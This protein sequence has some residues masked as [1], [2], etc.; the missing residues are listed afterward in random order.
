[1]LRLF[2]RRFWPPPANFTSKSLQVCL[3]EGKNQTPSVLEEQRCLAPLLGS[4]RAWIL[5]RAR[6]YS[7]SNGSPGFPLSLDWHHLKSWVLD[8]GPP[9]ISS[10]TGK[11]SLD[12]FLQQVT[13]VQKSGLQEMTPWEAEGHRDSARHQLTMPL[14]EPL[15]CFGSWFP[16]KKCLLN[17]VSSATKLYYLRLNYSVNTHYGN[18]KHELPFYMPAKKRLVLQQL[19]TKA[20]WSYQLITWEKSKSPNDFCITRDK[21]T[22]SCN[23]TTYMHLKTL[24]GQ[25]IFPFR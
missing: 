21:M 23:L 4:T 12:I 16:L 2:T 17:R 9:G 20:S 8:T 5:W 7:L 14:H 13:S 19:Y 18:T 15:H 10:G 25:N 6:S 3:G 11:V 22:T 24:P 1:M